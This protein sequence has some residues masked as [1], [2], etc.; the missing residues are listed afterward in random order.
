MVKAEINLNSIRNI[1]VIPR[2]AEWVQSDNNYNLVI[3]TLGKEC[4]EWYD[5]RA[6]LGIK[7]LVN[8][9][10][11]CNDAVVYTD[12]SVVQICCHLNLPSCH[13]LLQILI[14]QHDQTMFI[15]I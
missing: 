11:G 2:G 13:S 14:S 12:V 7:Q 15:I 8:S 3:I 9:N 6:D 1:D 10:A 5:G 4:R